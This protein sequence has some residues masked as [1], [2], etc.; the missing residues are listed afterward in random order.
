MSELHLR[1]PCQGPLTQRSLVFKH[2][3]LWRP[4]VA[5]SL[6]DVFR[7]QERIWLVQLVSAVPCCSYVAFQGPLSHELSSSEPLHT[8]ATCFLLYDTWQ[9]ALERQSQT[10]HQLSHYSQPHRREKRKTHREL[11]AINTVLKA[12]IE[13]WTGRDY[14]RVWRRG[15]LNRAQ[16]WEQGLQRKKKF[17]QSQLQESQW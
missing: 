15:H 5:D 10:L 1:Q 13:L 9:D 7:P 14:P 12:P 17:E 8:S 16:K 2:P 3:P 11:T 4:L 6:G